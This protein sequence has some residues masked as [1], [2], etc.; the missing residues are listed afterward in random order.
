VRYFGRLEF[1]VFAIGL[2]PCS[3]AY[4]Q[5]VA[6]DTTGDGSDVPHAT[7]AIEWN[8][9]SHACL[10]QAAQAFLIR[11]NWFAG[12]DL[13]AALKR[14]LD[15]RTERYGRFETLGDAQLNSRAPKD[16]AA[17]VTF[18]GL[19]LTVHERVT[20]ALRCVEAA[21]K[22]LKLDQAYKPTSAGGMR[23]RNTYRGVEVSNHVFGIAIDIEAKKNTCCSC[24]DPWPNHPLCKKKVQ[25]IYERMVMPRSWVIVF[26][27]YGF[28][29]LGHDALQDTMHFEFLGDSDKSLEGQ[30]LHS[31]TPDAAQA[32]VT[33]AQIGIDTGNG[34]LQAVAPK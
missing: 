4:A 15:Y 16:Y 33:G 8:G 23:F 25:S 29:W 2:S 7:V 32:V 18:M 17:E 31:Q 9:E 34:K 28:Y 5:K 26:E 10:E 21:L 19:T 1:L 20:P 14:A 27:R 12:P 24:V 6:P 13:K 30:W 22:D 11:K 3:V